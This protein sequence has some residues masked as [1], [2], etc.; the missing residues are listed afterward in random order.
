MRLF[1]I[2]DKKEIEII[3]EYSYRDFSIGGFGEITLQDLIT[4]YPE[5]IPSKDI[6]PNDPPRFL[7][8]KTEAGL[9][10]GSI[11]ILI[12]D[13]N[14]VPTVVEVKLMDNRDMRRN[15]L[16]QGIEYLSL[17]KMEWDAERFAEEGEHFWRSRNSDLD[18]E[19]RR[20][21]GF[22]LDEEFLHKIDANIHSNKLRLIIAADAV[23]RELR[24]IMEFLNETA[25]FD[26][27]G[28]EIR[29]F[30]AKG[31]GRKILAPKAVGLT[32]TTKEQKSRSGTRWDDERFFDVLVQEVSSPEVVNLAEELLS[33]AKE[34]SGRDVDWGIGKER[35][36][37]TCALLTKNERF[38][39]FSVYTTGQF[40]VNIGWNFRKQEKLGIEF[41]AKYRQRVLHDLNIEFDVR[42][43]ERGWPMADLSELLP[44]K[45]EDFKQIVRDFAAEINGAL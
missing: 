39:L 18:T 12:V 43:W 41:S 11:D 10:A 13:H 23:P 20:R 16:A 3:E 44:E 7:V 24:R 22:S 45:L 32:E 1:K 37:Y 26:I 25:A 35:G 40:S 28:V 34:V 36:S 30:A 15:V 31:S 17:L 4:N 38:S 5:M 8:I 19:A 9:T 14:G 2:T 6:D 21:F 27:W 29:L 42:T 33:F